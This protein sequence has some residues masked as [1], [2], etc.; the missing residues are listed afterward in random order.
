[1]LLGFQSVLR[2]HTP[3]PLT[4][5]AAETA[6]MIE[7]WISWVAALLINEYA[8]PGRGAADGQIS[9]VWNGAGISE[10]V[11]GAVG[12]KN[13]CG[14]G[15]ERSE[16]SAQDGKATGRRD[17]NLIVGTGAEVEFEHSAGGQ[18]KRACGERAYAGVGKW[19]AWRKNRA[20][21]GQD[22]SA[23]RAG[24]RPESLLRRLRSRKRMREWS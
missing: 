13:G 23:N 16:C 15:D 14:S 9:E 8:W 4:F 5:H 17:V 18:R 10:E 6:L 3:P 1:M 19:I 2:F 24:C 21:R 7:S 22:S 20:A 11:V 12:A